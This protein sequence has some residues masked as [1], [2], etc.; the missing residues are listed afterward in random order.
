MWVAPDAPVVATAVNPQGT[1]AK[2]VGTVAVRLCDGAMYVKRGGGSTAF[3]WYLLASDQFLNFQP[4]WVNGAASMTVNASAQALT[5][6]PSTIINFLPSN[7]TVATAADAKRAFLGGFTTGVALN[8]FL[9]RLVSNTD[10]MPTQRIDDSILL[11]FQEFDM[12][13][14]ILT[15]PRSSSAGSSTNLTAG[16]MRIWAGCVWG[17]SAV[18]AVGSTVSS[19][20]LATEW[21]SALTA[22]AGLFGMAFRWSSAVDT[23]WQLV[24]TNAP[25]GVYSQTV[26]DMGVPPAA[27]TLYRLR[28]RCVF[29]AGV[30]TLLASINDGTEVAI[31]LNVGPGA[32]LGS[33]APVTPFQPLASV[34]LVTTPGGIA[35]S[36]AA[37]QCAINYG[38]GVGATC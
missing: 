36:L 4:K 30:L 19:D 5:A 28:M 18:Q 32:A 10:S 16:T 25:A 20:T 38:L 22:T 29:V 23:N 13:W 35:K 34:R 24:T 3:G 37:A 27:N 33:T 26:T 14:D 7:S 1:L 21:P 15:T 2:P 6:G 9:Y 12:W 31:T 17:S 8:S 11:N